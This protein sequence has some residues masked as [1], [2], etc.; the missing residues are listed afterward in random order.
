VQRVDVEARIEELRAARAY[1]AS[2]SHDD[3]VA[4]YDRK[5]ERVGAQ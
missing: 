2:R 3:L 4:E 5:L 1:E